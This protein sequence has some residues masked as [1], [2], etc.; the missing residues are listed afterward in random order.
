MDD[1]SNDSGVPEK[2]LAE[3]WP[4][5]LKPI[6]SG[7]SQN[8]KFCGEIGR[9]ETG[10][11]YKIQSYKNDG[12]FC[13]KTVSP[14]IT[15]TDSRD[16]IG[17]NIVNEIDILKPLSH[18]CLPQ[19]YDFGG[20][21]SLP[22]YICTFHP[23][24]TFEKFAKERK[25][26]SEESSV[27]VITSLIDTFKYVHENGRSHC[28]FHLQN[29]MVSTDVI[30]DGVLIIDFGAG[31]RQSAG[32]V[33]VPYSNIPRESASPGAVL[34]DLVS[35]GKALKSLVGFLFGDAN[36]DQKEAYVEF[37]DK[38]IMKQFS[39]WRDVKESFLSVQN[40][41]RLSTR[42]DRFFLS[43][44]SPRLAITIPISRHI[45]VGD[46]TLAVINTDAF[47][48]LRFIKQLSFCEWFYPGGVHTR[49][50]HSL[51]VMGQVRRAIGHLVSTVEFRNLYDQVD[52]DALLLASLVHDIGHYPFAHVLEHYVETRFAEG[53]NYQIA[54]DIVSHSKNT[55]HILGEDN[56]LIECIDRYWG[57][58]VRERTLEIIS[59][60]R[61]DALSQ[62]LDGP[63][64]CDKLDYLRRDAL[65]CGVPFGDGLDDVGIM[66]AYRIVDAGKHLGI[67]FEGL[68]RV[69]GFLIAQ[70]QMLGSVYWQEYIRS[71][72]SMFHAFLAH[73]VKIEIPKLIAVAKTLK[74][75]TS[76]LEGIQKVIKLTKDTL[77]SDEFVDLYPLVELHL[78]PNFKKIFRKVAEYKCA[79][80]DDK[81][82]D[83]NN[84]K[85]VISILENPKTG[86]SRIPVKWQRVKEFRRC[87]V[88]AFRGYGI[89]AKSTEILID[90]PWGKSANPEIYVTDSSFGKLEAFTSFSHLNRTIFLQPTAYLNPI[91]VFVS[92]RVY[93]L[94][95]DRI[96]D[97]SKTAE[98]NYLA[99]KIP[100]GNVN[101]V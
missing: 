94:A 73:Y 37:C 51:G 64:D 34:T 21:E 92:P 27:F 72:I 101:E 43:R 88:E 4:H 29:V 14:H 23:G 86:A 79:F 18:K 55:V 95:C 41:S 15:N 6:A 89:E 87:F 100:K 11:A 71:V 57:E 50:E 35:F 17:K 19:I 85:I 1:S 66:K 78:K 9:G 58:V 69:E 77:E 24:I 45:S 54:K 90:V 39:S 38:I 16:Q 52:I 98:V 2:P 59:R 60:R 20:K 65:H 91:R 70:V 47:Q 67:S 82:R 7:L 61:T 22:Y 75:C 46:A 30:R 68:R 26:L 44:K 74:S 56:A 12:Y 10:I 48:R 99:G 96:E 84:H 53:G 3:Q 8:Y 80:E 81:L 40:P 63:I 33:N 32:Q 36:A 62:I 49:F 42:L 25:S 93:S 5:Y 13:L 83:E 28:D 97:I 76:D 31:K